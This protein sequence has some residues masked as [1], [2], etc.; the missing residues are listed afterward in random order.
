MGKWIERNAPPP[1]SPEKKWFVDKGS[2]DIKPK[3][4]GIITV[5]RVSW[6]SILCDMSPCTFVGIC[7][8]PEYGGS[9]SFKLCTKCQGEASLYRSLFSRRFRSS[10]LLGWVAGSLISDVIGLSGVP[11]AVPSRKEP[12]RRLD[13]RQSRSRRYR[14]TETFLACAG[15]RT[16]PRSRVAR[17]TAKYKTQRQDIKHRVTEDL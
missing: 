17:V 2:K 10:G 11:A 15:N 6:E 9:T 8:C 4:W 3:Q 16:L 1:P 13:E 14:S 5:W 7:C 12:S